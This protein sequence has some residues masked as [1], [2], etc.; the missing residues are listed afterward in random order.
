MRRLQVAVVAVAMV[1]LALLVWSPLPVRADVA[2]QVVAMRPMAAVAA[3]LGAAVL[4][5]VA[6]W[7]RPARVLCLSLAAAL[8]G[9]AGGNAAVIAVRGTT[10]SATTDATA[11][12]VLTWN[13]Q[14]GA[15]GA[16][17]VADAVVAVDADVV[18]LP[19]TPEALAEEVAARL[20]EFHVLSVAN[21]DEPS[22][23]TSL[24]ISAT[25]GDYRVEEAPVTLVLPSLVAVP[26]DG[27][28][29]TLVAVHA[30]A[31]IPPMTG[32][33]AADLTTLARLCER[34]GTILAGDF[35]ATVDHLSLSGGCRDAALELGAAGLGTWP[36][37]LPSWLGSPIDHVLA[38]E[39]W[40]ATGIALIDGA[41]SDH[42]A[43]VAQLTP[44]G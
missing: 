35:N 25:L 11:L 18:S 16:A 30:L 22:H 4:A 43:L 38:S 39:G 6:V 28:G 29:P 36:A 17:A 1:S 7:A 26:V 37:A 31:P 14:G 19:E 24:L 3:M 2:A 12:T 27:D 21:G 34:P 41:G 40:T 33:W 9:F 42:R 23:A 10:A 13:T 32:G 5:A 8:A 15:A 20:A 44:T